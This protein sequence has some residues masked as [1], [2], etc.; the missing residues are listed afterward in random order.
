[1]GKQIEMCKTFASKYDEATEHI[2]EEERDTIRKEVQATENWMYD[3]IG[4]QGDV[5]SH[6]D[7]VLTSSMIQTKRTALFNVCNPIMTKP[8]P[9]PPAPAPAPTPKA[10]EK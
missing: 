5:A 6:K 4:K 1:M 9:A 8:K 3:S 7:P 10:D 2:K